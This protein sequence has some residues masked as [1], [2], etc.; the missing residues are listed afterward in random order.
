M[1]SFK[2]W[3]FFKNPDV[4][5]LTS[6]WTDVLSENRRHLQGMI[7]Q[8]FGASWKFHFCFYRNVCISIPFLP[9]V[10]LLLLMLMLFW[11]LSD[12]TYVCVHVYGLC[13]CCYCSNRKN[14]RCGRLF[15]L[16]GYKLLQHITNSRSE[17]W[18]TL[19]VFSVHLAGI[20]H[21]V[22]YWLCCVIAQQSL[23]NALSRAI[24]ILRLC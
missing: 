20:F 11:C 3:F 2:V 15:S 14:L 18:R 16:S 24:Y 8:D 19:S 9:T 7:I 4:L 22:Y 10:F 6:L 21:I 17:K 13:C 12:R 5:I 23:C 1:C